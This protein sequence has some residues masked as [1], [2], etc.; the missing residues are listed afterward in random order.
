MICIETLLSA[1]TI[2]NVFKGSHISEKS[3][4]AV[5]TDS[6]SYESGSIFVALTGPNFDGFDYASS[7]L[8]KGCQVVVFQGSKS[9]IE[10]MNTLK[11]TYS[12]VMFIAAT[13][14]LEY[15]QEVAHLHLLDWKNQLCGQNL[16]KII[17]ITGSNGKTTT[18]EILFH[19]LDGVMPGKVH[20]TKGNFNNHIGVPLTLLGLTSQHEVVIVEM[21]TNHPGEIKV[22]CDIAIPNAGLIT[23]IGS[24][25]LEFFKTEAGVFAEKRI[26]FDSVNSNT[27]KKGE[28]IVDGDDDYLK[29]LE[30]TDG[31]IYYGQDVE[32]IIGNTVAINIVQDHLE[33]NSTEDGSKYYDCGPININNKYL[34]GTHNYKNMACAFIFA[35][36]LFPGNHQLLIQLATEFKPKNNRSVWH[37]IGENQQ[38][39][40]DAYN[41]NP[42]SMLVSVE[43]FVS[44]CVADK[45]DLKHVLFIV[46]DMNEL[47]DDSSKLHQQVGKKL[48]KMGVINVAFV[49]R[50]CR[51]YESGFASPCHLFLEKES[52]NEYWKEALKKYNRFFIKGSRSLQLESLMDI[53]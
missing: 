42:S 35:N 20:S 38:I 6:R 27:A 19:F 24:S 8:E 10:K 49:G 5:S 45:I 28:F 1:K 29:K 48:G 52:L 36:L 43:S 41:A 23:N 32:K 15:L 51:D 12:D 34:T 13:D 39:F 30:K 50:F 26:L 22:L 40:L 7:V 11:S 37:Q 53:K 25:H 46:G 21:G 44:K 17:G 31:L 2:V 18:K 9:N 47:G 33:I 3:C 16:P 14:T 4:F